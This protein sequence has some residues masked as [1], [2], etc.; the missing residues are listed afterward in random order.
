MWGWAYQHPALFFT[1]ALFG[2]WLLIVKGQEIILQ[3]IRSIRW[4]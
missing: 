1:L 4:R 3:I 2:E